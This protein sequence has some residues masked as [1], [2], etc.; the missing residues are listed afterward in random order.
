MFRLANLPASHLSAGRVHEAARVMSP[1]G[2]A[3]YLEGG[4]GLCK[5]GR[6]SDLVISYLQEMPLVVKECGEDVI[7]DCIHAAMKLSSM[8]SGEVIALD[9][10]RK[11][12]AAVKKNFPRCRSFNQA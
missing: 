5:L 2:L 9:Q 3:E 8:T 7:G 6:G 4:R 11:S 12:E 10:Q 1:A